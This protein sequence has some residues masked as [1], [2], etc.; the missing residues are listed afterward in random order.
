M[1]SIEKDSK[2]LISISACTLMFILISCSGSIN[3][4]TSVADGKSPY[5]A[6]T[7]EPNPSATPTACE[8]KNGRK[9]LPG[10]SVYPPDDEAATMPTV[11]LIN[12]NNGD[13]VR[14]GSVFKIRFK[15]SGSYTVFPS[16]VSKVEVKSTTASDWTLIEDK[17]VSNSGEVVTVDWPVCPHT[18]NEYCATD[19]DGTLSKVNGNNYQI[20]VTGHRVGEQTDVDTS[21]GTFTIDSE[22]P[23]L[24]NVSTDAALVA[25][26]SVLNK[27]VAR[28]TLNNISDGY[29]PLAGVCLKLTD[30][31]PDLAD[32]CW[33]PIETLI[34]G[35]P[36]SKAVSSPMA[37]DIFLGFRIQSLT[38]YAWVKD[39]AGNI[40]ELNYT[41]DA[42]GEVIW[43][44]SGV[45]KVTITMGTAISTGTVGYY[46][47]SG[48][49]LSGV[50]LS[51]G[52]VLTGFNFKT[53]ASGTNAFAYT[54][55]PTGGSINMS[56]PGTIVV[57]SDGVIYVKDNLR[58]IIEI[59]PVNGYWRTIIP[60]GTF[61]PGNIN[62]TATVVDP[63]RIALDD[64]EDLIILDKDGSNM[65]ILSVNIHSASTTQMTTLIGGGS[66]DIDSLTGSGSAQSLMLT[67]HD[68]LRWYGAFQTL[69]QG[70][71]L[72][73]DRDPNQAITATS[74]LSRFRLILYDPTDGSTT[75]HL[76]KVT[77]SGIGTTPA[78]NNINDLVPYG[79][80]IGIYDYNEQRINQYYGRFCAVSGTTCTEQ[81][82]V[83]F[84]H[85]GLFA[86]ATTVHANFGNESIFLSPAGEI[87]G[88]NAY[89]GRL[90]YL[91]GFSGLWLEYFSLLGSS[92]NNYCDN[93]TAMTPISSTSCQVRIK[94]AFKDRFGIIYFLDQNRIR[95]I[96]RDGTVQTLVSTD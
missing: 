25:D 73:A 67:Y 21:T 17:V 92:G 10:D 30:S 89:R 41:Y 15:V 74:I 52:S 16:F 91:S 3:D 70:R 46:A 40:S 35:Y 66:T 47:T 8:E 60:K 31:R 93:S 88:I 82:F 71:I 34:S 22:V 76:S 56:D 55:S 50:N 96:E 69:P 19:A 81:V 29:S 7:D 78:G 37:I 85:N 57:T 72:F 5:A 43:G 63:L 44:S 38:Y 75:H 24:R 53:D 20:K 58:G 95:F 77:F 39:R 80:L 33:M 23:R 13:Y 49:T 1:R 61:A 12:L 28:F 51:A 62:G 64:K 79:N 86:G 6:P 2:I 48:T 68:N 4:A 87:F 26:N 59:D 65:R 42:N 14:G 18:D 54:N 27:G 90:G 9:C 83:K 45:D 94:D 11:E 32:S 36:A 84:D